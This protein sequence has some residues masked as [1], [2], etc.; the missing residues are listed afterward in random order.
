MLADQRVT[1]FRSRPPSARWLTRG[2]MEGTAP[3]QHRANNGCGASRAR[4]ARAAVDREDVFGA[5]LT[6][7]QQL[8]ARLPLDGPFQVRR[9]ERGDAAQL[10]FRQLGGRG[11]RGDAGAV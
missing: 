10:D 4:L 1:T 3:R 9:R 5:R 11:V 8:A 7:I 6:D 2:T